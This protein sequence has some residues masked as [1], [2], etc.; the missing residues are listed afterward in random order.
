[1]DYPK[2]SKEA[3]KA[4][5]KKAL[6]VNM[7]ISAYCLKRALSPSVIYNWEVR[8]GNYS[9]PIFDRLMDDLP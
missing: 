8:D 2:T 4:V 6:K 5:A 3:A 1:M 9:K 7:S